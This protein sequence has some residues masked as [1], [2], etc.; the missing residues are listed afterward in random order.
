MT[1]SI[2]CAAL[3]SLGFVACA[4][5]KPHQ[6]VAPSSSASAPLTLAPRVDPALFSLLSN[7]AKSCKVDVKDGNLTCPQGEQRQLI[8]EF[9]SNQRPR[10]TAVATFA[11]AIADR[12]V[13][14]DAVA[15]SILHAAF[16]SPWGND[17]AKL[18]VDASDADKL[19]NGALRLPKVQARQALPAAVNACMLAGRSA[20]LYSALDTAPDSELRL[21]GARYLLSHGRLA[22]FPKVQEL[23]KD[24]SS[25][26]VLAALESPRNMF[27]WTPAEQAA[28]C[29]WAASFL[30]DQR[31]AVAA[32]AAS[33][34]S[35]CS[36]EW[37]DRLLDKGE[38]AVAAKT[39][40][41]MLLTA[42]RDL[43]AP[44]RTA[45]E[46]GPSDEQ[47]KRSRTL[48]EKAVVTTG[49]DEQTRS[50][51]LTTVA[52][53]W[54]D[55]DTLKLMRKL[56]K[57]KEVTLAEVARRTADS[58]EQRGA[59][60]VKPGAPSKDKAVAAGSKPQGAAPARAA[61]PAPTAVTPAN[62]AAPAP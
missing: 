27:S 25:A 46:G 37:V 40:N 35:S 33:V 2:L 41:G 43:C 57:T 51:A 11:A 44:H 55:Q 47:C 60:S 12:D 22:A 21:I 39:F 17:P 50:T 30:D 19:L 29:P 4:K 26:V 18:T 62:D 54:P 52:Y 61:A 9:V 32:K 45:R 53:Q 56:S 6:K 3:L 59:G 15:S 20:A 36:G 1:K 23:A 7:M 34:L 16:R 13:A 14:L 38:K 10:N 58:L 5:P 31:P 28:I 49:I 42:F 48:L 24:P 8:G